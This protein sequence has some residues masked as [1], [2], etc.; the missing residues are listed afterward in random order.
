MN[1]KT[2]AFITG[3]LLL[4][5]LGMVNPAMAQQHEEHQ[6]KQEQH[7]QKAAQKTQQHNDK[8]QQHNVKQEQRGQEGL[9]QERGRG[10]LSTRNDRRIPEDRFREG[11]GRDHYFHVNEGEFRSGRF[12][13][14]GFGFGFVD[15]WPVYW[16]FDDDVYV[17]YVDDE[18]FMFNPRFPGERIEV[19]IQ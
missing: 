17:D 8:V 10:R 3:T 4:A 11:F 5:T 2:A 14:G 12:E 19:V 15:P 1:S 6:N 13:F 16:G 7:N 18:Y 9:Y